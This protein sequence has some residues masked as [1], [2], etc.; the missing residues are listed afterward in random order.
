MSGLSSQSRNGS[1]LLIW[2]LMKP[3]PGSLGDTGHSWDARM[4]IVEKT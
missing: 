1:G 3:R 2:G 4:S